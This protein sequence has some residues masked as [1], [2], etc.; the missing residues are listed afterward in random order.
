MH[1][2]LHQPQGL[3]TVAFAKGS[4]HPGMQ[5]RDFLEGLFPPVRRQHRVDGGFGRPAAHGDAV[6][7]DQHML[8]ADGLRG[9][10]PEDDRHAV[11]LGQAFEARGEVHGVAKHRIIVAPARSHIANDAIAGVDADADREDRC[12]RRPP[13]REGR[14]SVRRPPSTFAR[15]AR[16]ARCGVIGCWAAERSRTP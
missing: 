10:R 13:P 8:G 9:V 7:F 16:T 1:A 11:F 6:E 4:E 12:G 14:G 3:G 15:P 5:V 2:T